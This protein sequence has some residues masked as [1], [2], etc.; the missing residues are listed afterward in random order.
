MNLN[1]KNVIRDKRVRDVD[2]FLPR[3][4]IWSRYFWNSFFKIKKLIF[5]FDSK[6]RIYIYI[7]SLDIYGVD[8]VCFVFSFGWFILFILSFYPNIVHDYQN[9]I[10]MENYGDLFKLESK[11]KK[12]FFMTKTNY[13]NF[14]SSF[15]FNVTILWLR[16]IRI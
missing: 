2:F 15:I 4:L 12:Y 14:F 10:E 8:I 9:G 3:P 16:Y 7:P 6:N 1:K 11:R 5:R 13:R